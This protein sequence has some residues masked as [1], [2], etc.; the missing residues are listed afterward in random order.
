MHFEFRL[1]ISLICMPCSIALHSCLV[2]VEGK[3]ISSDALKE[4][5]EALD[6]D[7]PQH[8]GHQDSAEIPEYL[9]GRDK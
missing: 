2:L 8:G 9:Q 6:K 1:L 5:E 3:D 7:V 4:K